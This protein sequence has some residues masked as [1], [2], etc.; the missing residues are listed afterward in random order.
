MSDDAQVLA[1]LGARVRAQRHA[2]GLTSREAAARAGL[3]P[4]FYS[5]LEGGRANIAFTRLAA[6]AA[7]LDVPVTRLV[8]D[9]DEAPRPVVALVGLRGAGKSTVGP[10]LARTLDVPFL[11]LDE[12]IEAA[13]NL[14]VTEI[15]A[16]HGESFYRRLAAEAL[17]E[18]VDA[19]RAIVVAVPGGLVQD[20]AARRLLHERCLTA[21]LRARPQDHFDRVQRQGDRRPMANRANAMDELRQI[22]A[23]R[24]PLYR[25]AD[26]SV[27]TSRRD[28]EGVARSLATSIARHGWRAAV[29]EG[30]T[31]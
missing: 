5:Q 4:R 12:R 30:S 14:S 28:A 24:E 27:D 22:L 17:R 29:P 21:W 7:A 25:Q 26:V 15:F 3:S 9:A 31:T 16:L 1:R 13:A 20:P 23:Q 6:V 10:L 11:E 8:D 18:L 2:R 19:G